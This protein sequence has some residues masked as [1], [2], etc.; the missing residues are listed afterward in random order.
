MVIAFSEREIVN[1]DPLLGQGVEKRVTALMLLRLLLFVL[2]IVGFVVAVIWGD[3]MIEYGD[4]LIFN[5]PL[6]F[7][8]VFPD[9]SEWYFPG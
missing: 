8:Q 6:V 5:P 9:G 7:L 4:Q 2:A 1:G 3:L